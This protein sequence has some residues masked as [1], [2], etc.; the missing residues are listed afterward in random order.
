[1]EITIARE[2][3]LK[4]VSKVQSI[5]ERKSNMPILSTI[6]LSTGTENVHMSATD[7]EL[8]LDQLLPCNVIESGSVTVSGRK[9]F[10]ILKESR[11]SDF[12]IKEKENHWVSIF[13]DIAKFDLACQPSDE[14][15]AFI[16]PEGVVMV[17]IDGKVLSDMINKTIYAVTIEDIGF[18]LAGVFTE[19]VDVEGKSFLRMVA[20]DGHR[21]SL[22]DNPL[23]QLDLLDLG[24]GVMIPRKGMNELNKMAS[25]GGTVQIGFKEKS[26][27]AKKDGALLVMRLLKAKF[28]DYAS[29]IPLEGKISIDVKR[30]LLLE[31]MRKM[32]ILSSERYRA[33]KLILD[34]NSMELVSSN[35]DLGEGQEIMTVQY[36]G[37]RLE[38]GFNPRYFVDTLQSMESENISLGFIDNSKPC[39]LRGE[40]DKGFL[41]VIMPMRI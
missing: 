31:A 26:C 35:P 33:V 11:A 27:V 29:V 20:T 4:A 40:A 19:K 39:I 25:E 18:K 37:E 8:G 7:L 41:G 14:F 3:L 30:I 17:D 6:L 1:M 16:E 12:H 9:L 32:L 38:M 10:E 24:E 5:I 23:D 21:L 22:V 34:T 28:P 15:P 36:A 13:D 2:E